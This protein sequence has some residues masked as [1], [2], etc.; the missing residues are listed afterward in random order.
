VS[1]RFLADRPVFI[2]KRFAMPLEIKELHIKAVVNSSDAQGGEEETG[3]AGVT[4]QEA[5]IKAC[6]E[7]VLQILKEKTER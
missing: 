1:R 2:E 3:A 6:V 5:I 7:Q 4:D